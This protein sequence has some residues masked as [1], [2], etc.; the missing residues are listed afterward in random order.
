MGGGTDHI[1]I[2]GARVHNLKNIDLSIPRDRLV[3]VTGLSGS[4]KSS[5]AFDTIYAE[6]VSYTHLDVY[7]RQGLLIHGGIVL[8][9]LVRVLGKANPWRHISKVSTALLTAFSTC[10]SGAALPINIRDTHEK[11]GVSNKIASF[12]LPLGATINM[13]GTALYECVAAIFIAQAYGIE[14]TI[15]MCIR[16]RCGGME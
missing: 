12:T 6:A 2:T 15:Q 4:G 13:N 14:L 10:S 1:E 11:C 5:L 16:D 3:V 9:T 8:P 7:K